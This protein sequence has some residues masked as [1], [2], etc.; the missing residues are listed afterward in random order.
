MNESE[1]LRFAIKS[2]IDDEMRKAGIPSPADIRS[3]LAPWADQMRP[4]FAFIQDLQRSWASWIE[5]NSAQLAAIKKT[6]ED[7][8]AVAAKLAADWDQ[9]AQ[10]FMAT[11]DE[12][13]RLASIGWTL[14]TQLSLP[15]LVD[16]MALRDADTAADFLI[17]KL[18]DTDP[19]FLRMERRLCGDPHLSEFGTVLPQCFRAIRMGD[20]AIAIPSLVAILERVIQKLNSDDLAAST[21]VVKTLRK[22]NEIARKAQRDLFCARIWLSLYT[23][24]ETLWEQFPRKIPEPP[25][26]SRPAIQHGRIEPPNIKSEVVRLLNTLETALALH[27]LLEDAELFSITSGK[28]G[29]AGDRQQAFIAVLTANYYLPRGKH[30]ESV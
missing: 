1:K 4:A 13:E 22:K 16:F 5:Q 3:I 24:V 20:Y 12:V 9:A 21:D 15:E 10:Q 8:L 28:N 7:G 19:E 17:K 27:D 25:V 2:K 29:K 23:V 14:P 6:I 26:L 11:L 18:D 30:I